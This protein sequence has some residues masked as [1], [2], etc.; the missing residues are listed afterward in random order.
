MSI[1]ASQDLG[2]QTLTLSIFSTWLN[3]SSLPGAA[4]IACVMLLAIAALIALERYGRR[5]QAFTGINHHPGIA[6]RI[7]LIGAK[8]WIAAL[9][10]ASFRWRSA[11]WCRWS[12]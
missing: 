4:Q 10:S 8:R 1:G 3:R 5:R 11:F 9:D 7:A 6:R 2:V 12:S